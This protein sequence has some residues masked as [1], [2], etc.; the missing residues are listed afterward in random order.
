M[1]IGIGTSVIKNHGSLI[2]IQSRH[3]L[4]IYSEEEFLTRIKNGDKF[5]ST[6]CSGYSDHPN[7]PRE[8]ISTEE[9]PGESG[10]SSYT[11]VAKI[12]GK[13][14]DGFISDFFF[15]GNAIFLSQNDM[16]KYQDDLKEHYQE[17]QWEAI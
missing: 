5:F 9:Y 1:G 13:E 4:G 17:L 14:S 8:L 7:D 10:E 3:P 12:D 16:K 15:T 11:Y 2:T 6:K